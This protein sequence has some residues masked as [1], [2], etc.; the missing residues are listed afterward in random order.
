MNVAAPKNLAHDASLRTNHQ[1]HQVTSLLTALSPPKSSIS[2]HPQATNLISSQT[3]D[4]AC[5]MY[6]PMP[7]SRRPRTV[8]HTRTH[9]PTGTVC[10]SIIS[11]RLPV[12]GSE[13][14]H[15]G[16]LRGPVLHSRTYRKEEQR[17]WRKWSHELT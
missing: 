7:D 14:G 1:H 2:S 4:N 10:S 11:T 15:N 6:I 17:A 16:R 9:K 5:T 13:V 12:V 3:I 8:L